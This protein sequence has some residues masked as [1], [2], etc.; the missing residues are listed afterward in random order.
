MSLYTGMPV[1]LASTSAITFSSTTSN[2]STPLS[3]K[4]CSLA[5]LRWRAPLLFA[6]TL[7]LC[8]V[9]FFDGQFL[10]FL[11]LAISSAMALF[12]AGVLMRRMRSRSFI[13]EVDRL[14]GEVSVGC[15]GRPGWP[16]VTTAWSVTVTP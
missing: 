4:H 5:T 15:S 6:Q 12:S 2:S 1:Q 11:V 13:D 16:P 8:E 3:R 7:G 9:L 10:A 14:V